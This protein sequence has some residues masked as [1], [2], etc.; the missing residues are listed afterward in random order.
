MLDDTGPPERSK[1]GNDLGVRRFLGSLPLV[2]RLVG[3]T[4]DPVGF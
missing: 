4:N 3:L 2:F 1:F